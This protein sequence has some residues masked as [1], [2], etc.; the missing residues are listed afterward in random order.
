MDK[1]LCDALQMDTHPQ[2]DA[3]LNR[4]RAYRKAAGLSYSALAQKAGLS[5]AALMGMDDESWG[6]TST[7]IRAV[8]GVILAAW[9]PGDVLPVEPHQGEAA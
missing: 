5:R 9:Q 3:I 2:I 4:L 7:T 6:P 8:E 1:V